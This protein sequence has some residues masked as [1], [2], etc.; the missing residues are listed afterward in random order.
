MPSGWPLL[1]GLAVVAALVSIVRSA[2]AFDSAEVFRKNAL[3]LSVEGG[4]GQ[5][6]YIGNGDPITDLESIR[7]G[8]SSLG[9]VPWGAITSWGSDGLFP[10]WRWPGRR[11]AR[12]SPSGRPSPT[13]PSSCSRRQD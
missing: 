6:L 11:A 12:V 1:A 5:Q 7:S 8:R 4:Y 9:W 3:V 13:S 10:T 2:P